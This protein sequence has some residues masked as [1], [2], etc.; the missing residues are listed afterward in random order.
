MRDC[1]TRLKQYVTRCPR[2]EKPSQR[3]L[4]SIFLEGLRNKTLH[5]HLYAKKHTCFN[6]CCLDAMDYDDNFDMPSFSSL[7]DHTK[8]RHEWIKELDS[9]AKELN[10]EQIADIIVR[11][12]EQLYRPTIT[13]PP[14]STN[15][16]MRKWCQLCK[17]NFTHTTQECQHIPRVLQ[18]QAWAKSLQQQPK[19][20]V[21]NS[22]RPF[23]PM[24][25]QEQARP[26][27]HV[28]TPPIA[29]QDNSK[30]VEG[31]TKPTQV[32]PCMECGG[33]HWMKDCPHRKQPTKVETKE[34]NEIFLPIVRHCQDCLVT[35]L[36]KDCPSK[37]IENTISGKATLTYV[38]VMPS[39]QTFET[40]REPQ[41]IPLKVVTRAQTRNNEKGT[42]KMGVSP[43]EKEEVP[44]EKTTKK[45]RQ[46]RSKSQKSQ[47]KQSAESSKPSEEKVNDALK[48][49]EINQPMQE[50]FKNITVSKVSSGGFVLV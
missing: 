35:H 39:P 32:G 49:K 30:N 3:R 47:G 18:E 23:L 16:P 10:T 1:V 43:R 44:K 5:A 38:D 2:E 4:I 46:K 26:S 14:E 20:Q 48:S 31:E 19:L 36:S 17:W 11:R 27:E 33:D 50:T 25:S 21:M 28:T 22:E 15:V 8:E 41:V 7:E 34:T 29:N 13:Y 42:E 24:Q 9:R 12:V 45:R 40:E 37:K 6:E